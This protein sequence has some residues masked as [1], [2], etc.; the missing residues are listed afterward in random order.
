MRIAFTTCCAFSAI[1]LSCKPSPEKADDPRPLAVATTTMVRDLVSIIGGDDVRVVGLMGP[2]VDPHG[3][4]PKIGD[5]KLIEQADAI[6]YNGLHLE[7]RFHTTLEAMARRGQNTIAV[8][9][10]IN[11][12][13]LLAPE[14]DFEGSH[15]PHVWGDPLL[16]AETIPTVVTALSNLLPEQAET[17]A[18]RGETYAA[19][20]VEIHQWATNT[21]A[22][23]PP[24]SRVLV[25]SHDAFFYFGRA[26]GFEVRGLQGLST[27]SEVGI[28][29]RTRLV[30]DLKRLKVP[31]VFP[32]TSVNDKGLEAV[33]KEAGVKLSPSELFSDSLG[34]PNDTF[35]H[36]GETFDRGTY[37][38]MFVHNITTIKQGLQP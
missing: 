4:I 15:D 14:E 9:K 31:T 27:V 17:F 5:T 3:Y 11:P 23:L 13:S 1:L 10:S 16:W 38:G 19:R 8:T 25:T 29:D 36:K 22:T 18:A 33:A 37:L 34:T 21:L 30:A 20:L 24:E 32:E 6:F 28:H 2:G 7:G 26:Y 12:Q 35:E